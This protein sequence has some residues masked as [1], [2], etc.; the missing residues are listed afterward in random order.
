MSE[1][2]ARL[3][4]RLD[5]EAG[6]QK[7]DET[8]EKYGF[9]NGSPWSFKD[10]EFQR[11]I[12]KDTSSRISV[13]KCSQ[14]GLSELM[15]QKLLAMAASLRHVRI[16]FTLPTKDM[17]T[18][19]SKD[20]V[21]GAIDQSDFYSG[22]VEKASNSASQKKIGSCMVYIAGSFGANS[23]ISVPAEVLIHDEVDF[24]NQVVLGKLNSRIRHASIVDDKGYRGLKYMFSTPTVDGFGIDETF[25]Q[26]SK[27]YYLV[28]CEH[29]EK[30]QNPQFATDFTIPGFDGPLSEFG[31][32][33]SF[34]PSVNL[35]EAR[36]N[37]SDCK[38]DLF[39][40][41]CDPDRRQWVA[42]H[43]DRHEQSYQVNP[44]DVPKYNTPS[45]IARQI[46]GYPLKSDFYNFVLGLPYSDADNSF[47]TDEVYK[48]S[49]KTVAPLAY[50]ASVVT[51]HTV[52]GMDIGKVCHLTVAIPMGTKLH[53]VWMEKIQNSRSS[54]AAPEVLKRFDYFRCVFMCID[55]LPDISLVN[56]L[57][58]ARQ[59]IRAV[60]YVRS[61]AGPTIFE[62]KT[63]E[64][65]VNVDRTKSLSY[66]LNKHNAQD[67]QYPKIDSQTD[68]MFEH[69]KT[70]KKI[71]RQNADGSFTEL[72]QTTSSNDHWV[73]S[74]HYTMLAAEMKF[75]M[76]HSGSGL[77]APVGVGVVRVGS[78]NE[79][80]DELAKRYI[81]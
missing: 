60:V 38:K 52:M 56:T 72:F 80:E 64:P 44:W 68:E 2:V 17:A 46:Q 3:R 1:L 42:L 37:C 35:D 12:I 43:P 33:D 29:C 4:M 21:D 48:M 54:P 11:E 55:S 73:H 19:F 24:S 71:R 79:V 5:R 32:E 78:A 39:R 69:L 66:L 27:K 40:S 74:L 70:T 28:R 22:M 75:G 62:E 36:I 61:I 6:M 20:R 49:V 76:G 10:H 8:V 57:L 45:E 77:T 58:Q 30:W 25:Q 9:A 16:I 67:I 13:R 63:H 34:L 53:V 23:A 65:I 41:L 18:A 59:D 7:L 50:L 47:I 14:V 15:V 26:G 31:R 81:W 51:Q